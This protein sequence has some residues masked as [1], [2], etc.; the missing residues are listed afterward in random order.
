M[1]SAS[2][3]LFSPA[4]RLQWTDPKGYCIVTIAQEQCHPCGPGTCNWTSSY[5]EQAGTY[6]SFTTLKLFG[7]IWSVPRLKIFLEFMRWAQPVW[8][9]SSFATSLWMRPRWWSVGLKLLKRSNR[10]ITPSFMEAVDAHHSVAP[11]L[12]EFELEPK[13]ICTPHL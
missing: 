10:I 12:L 3:H 9:M 1:Q 5:H 13:L 4:I 8:G 6:N 7:P 2:S 11:Q